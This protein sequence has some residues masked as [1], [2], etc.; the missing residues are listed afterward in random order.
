MAV[1]N[2]VIATQTVKAVTNS[3]IEFHHNFIIKL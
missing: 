1:V 2:R 3:I